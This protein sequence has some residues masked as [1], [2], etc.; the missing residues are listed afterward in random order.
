MWC[1]EVTYDV[2]GSEY[3]FSS[4]CE[5]THAGWVRWSDDVERALGFAISYSDNVGNRNNTGN[6]TPTNDYV[7]ITSAQEI[8]SQGLDEAE[9]ECYA[10]EDNISIL[11]SEVEDS[12]FSYSLS[13]DELNVVWCRD[14][15]Y[16]NSRNPE[17]DYVMWIETSHKGWLGGV[18]WASE[19]WG[20]A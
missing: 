1:R 12:F 10:I 7:W 14:A 16:S 17:A 9:T 6:P 11:Y 4:W 8:S 3:S 15:C 20:F 5:T 2:N 13:E 19:S 18:A